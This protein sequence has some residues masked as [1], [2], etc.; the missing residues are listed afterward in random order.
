MS[1]VSV[2][3]PGQLRSEFS[4]EDWF[5]IYLDHARG[6]RT[7]L[8]PFPAEDIQI[9]TNNIKGEQTGHAAI[10]IW[11]TMFQSVMEIARPDPSWNILDYGCGWGRMTRLLPYYFESEGIYGVDV[12]P[13]LI[14][15]AN[16]CLPT[17]THDVIK[18]MGELPYRDASFDL[19]FANSVF[20]HLSEPSAVFTLGELA[21]ILKPGG[22]LL[23]SVL[24]QKT[25]DSYYHNEGTRSWIT[26]IIGDRAEAVATFEEQGFVWGDTRRWDNYGIAIISDAWIGRTFSEIGLE[27]AASSVGSQSYKLAVKL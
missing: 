5:G 1:A 12:D 18:S 23:I 15:S 13:R 16:S 3:E 11:K 7:D 24:Q 26:T 20:S 8:V 19:I 14:E 2:L 21:R 25:L 22:V 27:P 9:I 6:D 17:L 10:A 4:E